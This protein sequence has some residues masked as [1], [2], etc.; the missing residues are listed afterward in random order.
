VRILRA[1]LDCLEEVGESGEKELRSWASYRPMPVFNVCDLEGEALAALI[2]ARMPAAQQPAEIEP[3]AAAEQVLQAWPVPASWGGDRAWYSPSRDAIQLPQGKSFRSAA[4]LCASWEH[5]CIHST[6][7]ASRL[8]RDLAGAFG[9]AKYAHEELVAELGRV[10]LGQ[11]LQIGCVLTNHAAYLQSWISVLRESPK[12]L[13][14]VVSEARQAV[15]LI[16]PE[17]LAPE[18]EPKAEAAS[19]SS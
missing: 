19:P 15:D 10:L 2:A 14:Q 18:P 13:L 8:K 12:V 4:A 17:L 3:I 6:G 9:S 5:V 1:Q 11:R 7:H 16:C